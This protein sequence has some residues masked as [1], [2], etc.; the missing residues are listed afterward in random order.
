MNR[1]TW[2]ALDSLYPWASSLRLAKSWSARR[3]ST[4][5]EP[6]L[7]LRILRSRTQWAE[8]LI[9]GSFIPSPCAL[10]ATT[11]NE[12]FQFNS[13]QSAFVGGRCFPLLGGSTISVSLRGSEPRGKSDAQRCS[14]HFH[15]VTVRGR[16]QCSSSDCRRRFR[17]VLLLQHERL[18]YRPRELQRMGR[19]ARRKSE[20]HTSELQSL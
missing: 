14:C 9:I 19:I 8:A 13:E 17:R 12:L 6:C 16:G 15:S 10:K 1:N 7:H 5:V 4:R 2:S 18:Q 11:A 20:E 3:I